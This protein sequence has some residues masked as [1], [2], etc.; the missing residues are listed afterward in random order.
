MRNCISRKGFHPA[1]QVVYPKVG[2]GLGVRSGA[3]RPAG[4]RP[5]SQVVFLEIWALDFHGR[6]ERGF[7]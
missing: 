4:A 3:D 7:F 2:T 1:A 6:G 5:F